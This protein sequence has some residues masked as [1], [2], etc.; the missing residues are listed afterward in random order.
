MLKNKP[1][2][3]L[4][5]FLLFAGL[6]LGFIFAK[7]L[8]F[9]FR[10]PVYYCQHLLCSTLIK[11]SSFLSTTLFKLLMITLLVTLLK[12][13]V[14]FRRITILRRNLI[15]LTPTAKLKKVAG[16]LR[17]SKRIIMVE[18]ADPFVFCLGF[19]RTKIVISDTLLRLLTPRQLRAVL[20]HEKYHQDHF[21]A[22]I[23]YLGHFWQSLLPFFPILKDQLN[24]LSLNREISADRQ[25][26]V[27]LGSSRPL[28]STLKK[29][30]AYEVVPAYRT[31][32]S[33]LDSEKNLEMRIKALLCQR[34]CYS[35]FS[36]Q[37]MALS[38]LVLIGL[39]GLLF[40]PLNTVKVNAAATPEVV[41]CLS[42]E[43]C[44]QACRQ[45]KHENDFLFDQLHP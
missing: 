1:L 15:P 40:L 17:L 5:L 25:A 2:A 31:F 41:A 38:L 30:L 44:I 36:R 24:Y 22:L 26:M 16:E 19:F 35:A 9:L 27:K 3:F 34:F 13:L 33:F 29:L 21:D 7:Y 6:L 11:I 23:M 39:L 12:T 45:E 32:P 20:H 28:V 10:V 42:D 18:N 43:S 14:G 8:P 4:I 37:N